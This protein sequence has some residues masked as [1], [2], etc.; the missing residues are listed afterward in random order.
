MKHYKD[1]YSTTS[2]MES[3]SFFFGGGGSFQNLWKPYN[4]ALFF[5]T[6]SFEI[7][8]KEYDLTC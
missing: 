7:H 8:P 5:S 4:I 1:P 6:G 3:K 2:M